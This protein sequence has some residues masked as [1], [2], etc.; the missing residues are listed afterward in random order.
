MNS[1]LIREIADAG[2]TGRGGGGFPTAE[3]LRVA[4]ASRARLI[5]N[6]C[7]GEYG[8][9]KDQWV[10][11]HH[12]AEIEVA[13]AA[14]HTEL[15]NK[16]FPLLA[17]H[18]GRT[19]HLA[20][21]FGRAD[22]VHRTASPRYNFLRPEVMAVPA[23]YV[24]SE[25]SALA[26]FAAGA[27]ARPV[28]RSLPLAEAGTTTTPARGSVRVPPTLVLNAETVW[29]IAQIMAHGASW[30]RGSGSA[31]A[32]GPRLV[33]VWGDVPRTRVMEAAA[34]DYIADILHSA[35][36]GP[37]AV[38]VDGLSGSWL[39][40]A[41]DRVW[42]ERPPTLGDRGVGVLRVLRNDECPLDRVGDL[43]RIGV[44]ESAGQCGP[45]MFG[46]P[47]LLNDW[48]ELR[49]GRYQRE[50]LIRHVLTVAGRGACG[51]PDGV[52][53]MVASA[54]DVFQADLDAHT[55]GSCVRQVHPNQRV[56]S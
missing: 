8:S 11:E 46:L 51:M 3:K 23:R 28:H 53:R 1:S 44:N 6:A 45:C 17:V 9:V 48:T 35:N 19:S 21:A 14:L 50:T 20:R 15:G 5:I 40:A 10:L 56:A 22:E 27:D 36:A 49:A 12:L 33:T 42:Q 54:V 18:R 4:R 38:S 25:S 47:A 13:L 52:S 39:P 41:E 32:P 34:G 31:E 55:R 26:A 2:L 37:G 7:D 43:L 29:R 30:F 16:E 24:S